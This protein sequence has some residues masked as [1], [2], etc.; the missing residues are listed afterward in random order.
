ML[1][2]N[3]VNTTTGAYLMEHAT[4]RQVESIYKQHRPLD[5]TIPISTFL[6]GS[7]KQGRSILLLA[8]V[9]AAAIVL[10]VILLKK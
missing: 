7:A 3:P 5:Q 9:T 10:S 2:D 1:Q 6:K 4:S 8:I